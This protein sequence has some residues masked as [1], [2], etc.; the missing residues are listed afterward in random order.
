MGSRE[1]MEGRKVDAKKLTAGV[2]GQEKK[3]FCG[4]WIPGQGI[5]GQGGWGGKG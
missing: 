2:A 5:P 3:D 4:F 1:G